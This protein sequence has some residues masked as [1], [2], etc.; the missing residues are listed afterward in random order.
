MGTTI[1][2][3]IY[4][5][6]GNRLTSL[7]DASGN[8]TG[9]KAGTST[10]SYDDNGNLTSDGNRGTTITYNPLNL[11]KTVTVNS[12]IYT[13]DYDAAGTKHKYAG[14]IVTIKYAGAFEYDEVNVLKRI[15][16][17][18]GQIVPSGDTLAFQYYLKDHLGNVR[19]VFDE[20][21]DI[22]QQTDY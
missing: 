1:D 18:D 16:L 4:H 15:G 12:Q 8:N 19:L 22:L 5:Y 3:L 21:G 6:T 13:Y 14:D 20:K 7:N 17:S 10:Y 9:V 11:P 2:Q